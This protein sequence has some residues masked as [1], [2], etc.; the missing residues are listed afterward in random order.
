P[1]SGFWF[2]LRRGLCVSDHHQRCGKFTG[3]GERPM[4]NQATLPETQPAADAL[5]RLLPAELELVLL[6]FRLRAQ[7]RKAWLQ[8]IWQT[9]ES[10][11]QA[12][13]ELLD[14]DDPC[15]EDRWIRRDACAQGLSKQIASAENTLNG[16]AKTRLFLIG[17]IFG[18]SAEEFD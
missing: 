1:F 4:S 14:A 3:V 18:L 9:A 15:E 5:P 11:C 7:R 16:Y 17:K 6:S 13:P 12:T 10:Q 8:N 2:C